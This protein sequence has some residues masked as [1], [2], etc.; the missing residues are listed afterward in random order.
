MNRFVDTEAGGSVN[1]SHIVRLDQ[2]DGGWKAKLT[3]GDFVSISDGTA[4]YLENNLHLTDD[5]EVLKN[6]NS[7][8]QE[9]VKHVSDI[10]LYGVGPEL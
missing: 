3:G 7:T 5:A 6:I 1:V 4:E 10:N 9:L 8:L 2:I